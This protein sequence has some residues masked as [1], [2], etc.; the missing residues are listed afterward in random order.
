[1]KSITYLDYKSKDADLLNQLENNKEYLVFDPIDKITLP[2]KP[3]IMESPNFL[4][5]KDDYLEYR[6]K[7]R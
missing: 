6:K 4:L 7:D 1:M 5:T 3:I 2:G